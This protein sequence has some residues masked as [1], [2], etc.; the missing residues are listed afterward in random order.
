MKHF[1]CTESDNAGAFY[2]LNMKLTGPLELSMGETLKYKVNRSGSRILHTWEGQ[3]ILVQSLVQEI[4][5]K[6]STLL[7]P[8]P[9]W[10]RQWSTHLVVPLHGEVQ[11]GNVLTERVVLGVD[12]GCASGDLLVRSNL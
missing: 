3:H 5:P 10:T 6:G 4:G 2:G 12:V 8:P 7:T 9:L 11:V 1:G